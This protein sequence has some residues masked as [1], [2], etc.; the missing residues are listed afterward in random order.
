[1]NDMLGQPVATDDYLIDDRGKLWLVLPTDRSYLVENLVLVRERLRSGSLGLGRYL[2]LQHALK[3]AE[4]LLSTSPGRRRG[5]WQQAY[6]QFV[7]PQKQ[8]EIRQRRAEF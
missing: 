6:A 3:A 7:S 4:G 8:E 1:M 2:H 5:V